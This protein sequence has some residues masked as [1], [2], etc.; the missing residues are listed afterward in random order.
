MKVDTPAS[1]VGIVAFHW[2]EIFLKDQALE[3]QSRR[4]GFLGRLLVVCPK[5]RGDDS[6]TVGPT[7]LNFVYVPEDLQLM[8]LNGSY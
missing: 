7:L 1:S 2:A 4:D 6:Q 5:P 8:S 3:L